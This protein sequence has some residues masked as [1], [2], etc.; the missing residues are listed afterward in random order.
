MIPVVPQILPFS[1]GEATM[2]TGDSTSLTCTLTKGDL[3]IELVWLHN[4]RTLKPDG[5]IAILRMSKK[6]S[7]LSFD[8]LQAEDIGEYT[9]LAK[10]KAGV[11]SFSTYLNVNGTI[12]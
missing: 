6:I 11:S 3:P 8:S 7:T 9:C 10:N 5:N 4:N 2:N 12:F 1:F